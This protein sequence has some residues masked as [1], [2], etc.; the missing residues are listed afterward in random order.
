MSKKAETIPTQVGQESKPSQSEI[1]KQ[2]LK[3]ILDAKLKKEMGPY[4]WLKVI[5]SMHKRGMLYIIPDKKTGKIDV[6]IGAYKIK[7]TSQESLRNIPPE[8]EGEILYIP[9]YLPKDRKVPLGAVRR[10]LRGTDITSVVFEDDN[11]KL[12]EYKFKRRKK[13]A[14]QKA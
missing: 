13:W 3:M 11:N 4:A 1:L 10:Y 6:L 7:D 2:A 12:R 8:E 5:F 14:A 9:F